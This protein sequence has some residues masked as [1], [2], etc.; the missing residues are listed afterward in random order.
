VIVN[1]IRTHKVTKKDNNILQLIDKYI[2]NLK[3]DSVLV[4]TSKI[5]AICEG[6]LVSMEKTTRDELVE[7]EADYYL[8]RSLSKWN[9]C[10][11]IK[12]NIMVASGG[13]DQ[14]NGDDNFILWPKNPQKS[15]NEIRKHIMKKFSLNNVGVIITDSK[16]TPLRWGVTGVAISHSGFNA[17][18]SYI[19]KPD[20]FNKLMRVEKLNIAD[21]LASAAVAVMGEGSEQQ[22]LAII[23]NIPIIEFQKSNPSKKELEFLYA[24]IDDDLY[25]PLITSVKWKK[26]KNKQ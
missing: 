9:V 13:V 6:Q 2:T 26:G 3:E 20:I 24:N 4:V 5:V 11:S 7:Q 18:Y 12:N 25:A 23:T 10:I 17:L 14:S 16:T 22:P 1:P 8:P 15:A 19:G 21:S